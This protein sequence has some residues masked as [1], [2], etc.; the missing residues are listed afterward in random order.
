MFESHS[1]VGIWLAVKLSAQTRSINASERNVRGLGFDSRPSP[2]V[3][4]WTY[5]AFIGELVQ[6]LAQLY[7]ETTSEDDLEPIR[8]AFRELS[9]PGWAVD[10][11]TYVLQFALWRKLTDLS[12]EKPVPGIKRILPAIVHAWNALKGK[13]FHFSEPFA[14]VHSWVK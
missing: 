11:D 1:P 5:T 8:A 2:G 4:P 14:C 13:G 12:K 10:E 9:D 3:S 6:P 7:H